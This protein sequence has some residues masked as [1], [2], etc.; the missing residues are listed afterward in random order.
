P[1][2][3]VLTQGSVLAVTSNA[4]RTSPVKRGKFI[5]ENLLNT[6]PPPPPPEVPELKTEPDAVASGS[7]RQRMEQHRANPDCAVCHEKMDALGFAFE[8]FDAAGAWRTMDGPFP[9]DPSGALPDGRTFKDPADL[10]KLL[11]AEP[12]KFR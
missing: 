3:G 2:A 8:N 7:L 5:M 11:R 1:R 4:T 6:P 9:I 10:R 12:E